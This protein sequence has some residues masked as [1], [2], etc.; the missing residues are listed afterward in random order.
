MLVSEYEIHRLLTRC[1]ESLV[2]L[3]LHIQMSW[4]LFELAQDCGGSECNGHNCDICRYTCRSAVQQSCG[5]Q[6]TEQMRRYQ[7]SMAH[8]MSLSIRAQFL[9]DKFHKGGSGYQIDLDTVKKLGS[10]FEDISHN[11]CFLEPNKV[12]DKNHTRFRSSEY[13]APFQL[14]P[15]KLLQRIRNPSENESKDNLRIYEGSAPQRDNPS[16]DLNSSLSSL[17]GLVVGADFSVIRQGLMNWNSFEMHIPNVDALMPQN[18]NFQEKSEFSTPFFDSL[19]CN[20]DDETVMSI[21]R[22]DLDTCSFVSASSQSKRF[23]I[24]DY[25]RIACRHGSTIEVLGTPPF[26]N[27]NHNIQELART[28]IVGSSYVCSFS[29]RYKMNHFKKAVTSRD[30]LTKFVEPVTTTKPLPAAKENHLHWWPIINLSG[31]LT[32]CKI[33][34][35]GNPVTS[36]SCPHE[37]TSETA[38]QILKHTGKSTLENQ[39]HIRS[40]VSQCSLFLEPNGSKFVHQFGGEQVVCSEISYSSL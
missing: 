6:R 37:E 35:H 32:K 18:L 25:D 1:Q 14:R 27:L 28:A 7:S 38:N 34:N 39:A 11:L 23:S 26:F 2:D 16:F 19:E 24:S 5:D 4:S 29:T 40:E 17:H 13:P 8:L 3:N 31:I 9:I 33:R 10:E 22:L 15:L 20:S 21:S 30:L 36:E 12:F